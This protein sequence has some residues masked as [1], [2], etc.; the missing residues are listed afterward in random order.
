MVVGPVTAVAAA[1]HHRVLMTVR[2]FLHLCVTYFFR[3][4]C[5][6]T[7][8]GAARCGMSGEAGVTVDVQYD[9]EFLLEALQCVRI[10]S[11]SSG[12]STRS[13]RLKVAWIWHRC[14]MQWS[15]TLRQ[16]RICMCSS[17][18]VN[19]VATVRTPQYANGCG[20]YT[21]PGYLRPVR[22]PTYQFFELSSRPDI[23]RGVR[24]VRLEM[25][26]RYTGGNSCR[27]YMTSKE[28]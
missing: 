24:H 7:W 16:A 11:Y 17:A 10:Y 6:F 19:F 25:S 8:T 12:T 23:K 20:V 15:L 28:A 1:G 18:H 13:P 9:L 5:V 21:T 27:V 26:F 4:V 14:A 22:V 3:A 2:L